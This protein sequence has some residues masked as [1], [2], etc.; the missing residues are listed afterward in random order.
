FSTIDFRLKPSAARWEGGSFNVAGIAALGASLGLLLE[1]G[2]EAIFRRVLGL[3]DYLVRRAEE[4]GAELH[5]SRRPEDRSGIVSLA[6]PG[7][8][9]RALVA[10]A[11]RSGIAVSCRAGRLRVSPHCYNT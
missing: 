10:R 1:I 2:I 9:P 4:A 5:S 8:D 6:W 3:T 7:R 11:R